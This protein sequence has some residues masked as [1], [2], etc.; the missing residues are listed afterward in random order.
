MS[1]TCCKVSTFECSFNINSFFFKLINH[2]IRHCLNKHFI[3]SRSHY[4]ARQVHILT[5]RE[6]SWLTDQTYQYEDVVRLE[7]FT[8]YYRIKNKT[9]EHG[10]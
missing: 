3:F 4:D 8:F 2:G 7:E 5:V 9:V 1:S 6:S 10:S